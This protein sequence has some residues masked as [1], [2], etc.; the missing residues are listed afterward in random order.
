[1]DVD[2]GTVEKEEDIEIPPKNSRPSRVE[3]GAT[4]HDVLYGG[5]TP[6]YLGINMNARVSLPQIVSFLPN[7]IEGNLDIN[8]IGGYRVGIEGKVKTAT[9]E[10]QLAL[11]IKSNPSG[12]PIPDKLYFTVGG[13]EPGINVDSVGVLWITGGGGGFDKLYESIY[14]KDG[15]PPITLLLH[16]EFDITKILTGSADLELSLRSISI[17]F[18]DLSL[19]KLED[20]KFVDDGIIAIGWY[21]N[22]SFNLRAGVNSG[23]GRKPICCRWQ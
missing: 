4:I 16:I 14:G 20:A 15:L 17:S 9:M 6:G 22:F 13:F 5:K 12:A 7:K 21:P 10:M 19:K 23:Y 2:K 18:D 3:G 11:V 1:M 8:T